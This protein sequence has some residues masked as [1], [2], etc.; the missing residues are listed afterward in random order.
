M[1]LPEDMPS[2]LERSLT[3]GDLLDASLV[4]EVIDGLE[5]G[6]PIKWNLI[7]A[8]QLQLEKEGVDEADD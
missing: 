2:R 3:K 4:K 5:S 8:R 1:P 6:K 7:L